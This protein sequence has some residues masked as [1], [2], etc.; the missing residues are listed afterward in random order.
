MKIDLPSYEPGQHSLKE[1]QRE[2]TCSTSTEL[3]ANRRASSREGAQNRSDSAVM[4]SADMLA[5]ACRQRVANA[6]RT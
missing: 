4:T 5:Q 3:G 1:L 2:Q 6:K